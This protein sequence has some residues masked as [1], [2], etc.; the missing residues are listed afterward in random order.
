[1]SE[2]NTITCADELRSS[3]EKEKIFFIENILTQIG[4]PIKEY[5]PSGLKSNPNSKIKLRKLIFDF[6]NN[7]FFREF[8]DSVQIYFE[9]N[10]I[11][12]LLPPEKIL[13]YINQKPHF[14]LRYRYSS[15]FEQD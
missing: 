5:F 15:C 11:A 2:F 9:N 13:R 6:G 10:L 14:E 12:E 3:L 1:M 4:L 8:E 7:I